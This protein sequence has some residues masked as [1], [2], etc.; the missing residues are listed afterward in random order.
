MT[1]KPGKVLLRF[2]NQAH[3]FHLP[4]NAGNRHELIAV[5]GQVTSSIARD[6]L[7]PDFL[8]VTSLVTSKGTFSTVEEAAPPELIS[9]LIVNH[10]RQTLGQCFAC[11]YT[12]TLPY[13]LPFLAV[14]DSRR[15]HAFL[16][17][18]SA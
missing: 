6:S 14:E 9:A 16:Q 8:Q 15:K 17:N 5:L 12:W 10:G 18:P 2:S 4:G 7:S 3:V 13:Q 1:P 11:R